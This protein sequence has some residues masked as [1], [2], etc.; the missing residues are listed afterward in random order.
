MAKKTQK[1]KAKHNRTKKQLLFASS[2]V[3]IDHQG[4]LP[5]CRILAYSGG[6]FEWD[7]KENPLVADLS[8]ATFAA[9]SIP[10]LHDHWDVYRV[11]H[12]T[13]QSIENNQ[14]ILEGVISGDSETARQIVQESKN[15]FPWQASIGAKYGR[16]DFYDVGEEVEVNGRVFSGPIEVA[17]GVTIYETSFVVFGADCN[18]A[19]QVFAKKFKG[20][21]A[22]TFSEYVA[23]LG[24]DESTI[25]DEVRE[26]LQKAFDNISA[27]DSGEDD[28]DKEKEVEAEDSGSATDVSGE[29][30]DI[31]EDII[32]ELEEI[33][34]VVETGE[35][36]SA[37][38]TNANPRSAL[39]AYR[40]QVAAENKRI[41]KIR[42]ICGGKFSQLESKA[43]EQG[44]SPVV[45]ENRV[46]KAREKQNR[47]NP[48]RTFAAGDTAATARVIEASALISAGISPKFLEANG[49]DPRVIDQAESKLYR[50]MG[51]QR[52]IAMALESGGERLPSGLGGG[53]FYSH[54]VEAN[55]RIRA[56]GGGTGSF[57]TISLP[58]ILSNIANKSLLQA[59]ES[60]ES[61]LMQIAS[62]SSHADFKGMTEYRLGADGRMKKIGQDGKIESITLAEESYFNQLETLGAMISLTRQMIINDDLSAF[63]SIPTQMGQ[64]AFDTREMVGWKTLLDNIATFFTSARG[65][66]IDAPLS[67]DGI[68]EAEMILAEQKNA[69]GMPISVKGR[70]LIV[71]PR[72][73]PL[74]R[75][76][77][78]S[79]TV[80]E[81]T[82]VGTPSPVDNPHVNAYEP[83]EVPHLGASYGGSNSQW[84]MISDPAQIP[85]INVAFLNGAEAPIIEESD[86]SFD[87]LGYQY[88]IYMDFG[89]AMQDYRGA[90]YSD[91]TGED[92]EGNG[93]GS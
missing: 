3:S 22:M 34:T 6:K 5:K 68:S 53:G 82:A 1:I 88:R 77:Y 91:G 47:Q 87:T 35:V 64:L 54:A 39:M 69:N 57:S 2:S 80:N 55:R 84:I 70:Y 56:A 63:T 74:A 38:R 30:T 14:V 28:P 75:T 40:K 20:G 49:Y 71:P 13:R 93:T 19:S 43:I 16:I 86:S 67:I 7:W 90:V 18:T 45:V 24:Y 37:K 32:T 83:I 79:M 41:A 10:L 89:V 23:S 78:T 72:L 62:K 36:V 60:R 15:G 76:L 26:A 85:I 61:T 66:S 25:S 21:R 4:D 92:D 27:S 8:T 9:K 31:V 52:I 58:G 11:G 44:W 33:E 81:T 50:G 42:K 48:S 46:L 17:R 29:V 65:N 59:Y 73:Y 51:L 12:T